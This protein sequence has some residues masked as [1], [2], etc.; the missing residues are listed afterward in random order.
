MKNI[1]LSDSW[2]LLM[3]MGLIL[4]SGCSAKQGLVDDI[5]R[6]QQATA[7]LKADAAEANSNLESALATG[8]VGPN[9]EPF[10]Q[11]SPN[12][13][14]L[15]SVVGLALGVSWD[16][17][18]EGNSEVGGQ[19]PDLVQGL[20]SPRGYDW[21]GVLG[22]HGDS[23]RVS[24]RN[25]RI[26]YTPIDSEDQSQDGRRTN[27]QQP[28]IARAAGGDR[29]F[30]DGPAVSERVSQE[31]REAQERQAMIGLIVAVCAFVGLA[32]LLLGTILFFKG[33]L[34]DK[35]RL[36]A[37]KIDEWDDRFDGGE[38]EEEYE[39]EEEE[40]EEFQDVL[41]LAGKDED[42]FQVFVNSDGWYVYSDGSF[43]ADG[44]IVDP[45]PYVEDDEFTVT[46]PNA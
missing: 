20:V 37:D 33:T 35:L 3:V 19:D 40:E 32:V 6:A 38:D 16:S 24:E 21:D 29:G 31:Q 17:D 26:T 41:V 13:H 45:D 39:E 9:A 23:Y 30:T 28:S 8:E 46:Q 2:L 4:M 11:G 15:Y 5:I 44:T 27:R 43:V 36:L 25:G 7:Q 14:W 10:C 18:A 1:K 34:D 12:Q 42:G 22:V